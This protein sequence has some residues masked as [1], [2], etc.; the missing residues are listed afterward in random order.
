[1]TASGNKIGRKIRS[2]REVAGITQEELALRVGY[3]NNSMI[4]QIESGG[5]EP[6]VGQIKEL[7]AALNVPV[8]MIVDENE[9]TEQELK[10]YISLRR[11]FQDE[12]SGQPA[13][14]L[15]AVLKLLNVK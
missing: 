15:P 14:I 11:L 7:A 13:E 10:A 2:L 1:M 4:S 12:R 8:H 9:Y 5:K 6:S 3:T